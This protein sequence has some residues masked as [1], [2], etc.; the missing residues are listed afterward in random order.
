MAFLPLRSNPELVKE[1]T[2][3]T[4][5]QERDALAKIRAMVE[6]LGPDSYLAA[7]F[8]GCFDIA[9]QN[10][11]YDFGDSMKVRAESA[12]RDAEKAQKE[13]AAFSDTILS[14]VRAKDSGAVG[15]LLVEIDA[16]KS[17][18]FSID[19]RSGADEK[20]VL[21]YDEATKVMTLDRNKSGRDLEGVREFELTPFDTLKLRIYLDKSSIEIFIN[22][23]EFVMSTRVYPKD[24][25]TDIVFTPKAETLEL[26]SVDY[27]SFEK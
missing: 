9:D 12:N 20:T 2:T 5:Q 18:A 4:K 14:G 23:G 3:A 8:A 7:A 26:L 21:S 24:E 10:I 15:E 11:E 17:K 19:L 25:S 1:N 6:E 16:K 22:D 27:Y 13:L